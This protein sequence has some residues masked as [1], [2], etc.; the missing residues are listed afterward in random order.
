MARSKRTLDQSKVIVVY[1]K[2]KFTKLMRP[3]IVTCLSSS[4]T[5][6]VLAFMKIIM[7]TWTINV[8][9]GGICYACAYSNFYRTISGSGLFTLSNSFT[10]LDDSLSNSTTVYQN[11]VHPRTSTPN[12]VSTERQFFKLGSH[13]NVINLSNA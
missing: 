1:V 13:K 8:F 10:I 3:L 7:T 6:N 12:G 11:N 2:M 9:L 4:V 5:F